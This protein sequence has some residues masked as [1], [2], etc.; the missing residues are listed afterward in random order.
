MDYRPCQL[1]FKKGEI[2]DR[3]YVSEV[4]AY[5]KTWGVMPDQHIGNK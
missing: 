4:D 1:I 2:I 3:V 5:I